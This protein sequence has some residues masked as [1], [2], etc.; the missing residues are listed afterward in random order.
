M[1]ITPTIPI[2]PKRAPV[3]VLSYAPM[4]P[5]MPIRLRRKMPGG[6]S[7]PSKPGAAGRVER[8]QQAG[9]GR[10][11]AGPS[12]PGAAD[13]RAQQAGSGRRAGGRPGAGP[14]S[15]ERPTGGRE[16]AQQAGSGRRAAG[17][18]ERAQQAGSGRRAA[19]RPGAA[20]GRPAIPC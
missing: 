17:R 3:G 12:K 19:G 6:W 13:G 20:D 16:R 2:V 15:R 1:P 10:R 7:G 14:A 18:V 11:A 8:A 4:A 5:K 9:S